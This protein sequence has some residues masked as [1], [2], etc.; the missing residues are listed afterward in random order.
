LN[1]GVASLTGKAPAF[2]SCF[3]DFANHQ[4]RI[5]RRRKSGKLASGRRRRG[6]ACCSPY[7][8]FPLK[9][10]EVGSF[11]TPTKGNDLAVGFANTPY[12]IS[13]TGRNMILMRRVLRTC[14]AIRRQKALGQRVRT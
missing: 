6:N 13:E 10:L 2:Y 1:E 5:G 12:P 4:Q 11:S 3:S 9:R 8:G 14:S 7:A